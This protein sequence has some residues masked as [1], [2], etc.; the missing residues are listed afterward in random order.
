MGRPDPADRVREFRFRRLEKPEEFR[1]AEELER[2]V[3]DEEASLTIT[4]P[5]L[6]AAQDHGGLV[7]GAFADIYLAGCTISTIGWDGTTLY[8]VSHVTVVRPEYQNHHVGFRLKAF[9][10]E[11]VLRLGLSEIRWTFDPLVSRNA[12][13]FVRR[14]GAE[15]DRY[16]PHYYGQLAEGPDRGVETDRV[17]VRW[18]IASPEVEHR[19]GAPPP[20]AEEETRRWSASTPVVETEPGE[21][22]LRLPTAVVEPS[23]PAVQLEI[24]FDLGSIRAH[25]AAGVRRWRLAVRDAFR[26]AFDQGYRVDDF[27]VASI[28]HERR[29]FYLLSKRPAEVP[30]TPA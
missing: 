10:R 12:G 1:H 25:E 3:L 20:K 24:P 9:Q 17:L 28:D 18:K 11:E 14:L 2:K 26:S 27:A 22:G 7:L 13:L 15:P 8:H 4:A 6:R 23:D 19:L 29:S 30:P 5:S 16:L 21:S